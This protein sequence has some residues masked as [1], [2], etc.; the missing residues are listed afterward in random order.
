VNK[1]GKPQEQIIVYGGYRLVTLGPLE[2]ARHVEIEGRG[3][4]T[5]FS[6]TAFP[7]IRPAQIEAE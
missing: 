4:T 6:F 7:G 5:R 1:N 2:V 3:E